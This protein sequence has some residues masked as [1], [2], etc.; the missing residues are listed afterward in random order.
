MINFYPPIYSK[1]ISKMLCKRPTKK[2]K[3]SVTVDDGMAK[4]IEQLAE[5]HDITVDQAVDKAL[6]FAAINTPPRLV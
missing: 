1:G 2:V 4:F 3:L 5:K 6:K